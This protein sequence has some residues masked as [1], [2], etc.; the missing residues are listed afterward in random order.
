MEECVFCKIAKGEIKNKKTYE[1]DN[2][3]SVPDVKPQAP[4]HSLIISKKHFTTTLDL[5]NSLG[6]SFL[7]CVKN[8]ALKVM[9][10]NNAEGFNLHNNNFG[11]AGQFVNH[12]HMH[13][14]PRK[15]GDNFKPC[16]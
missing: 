14:V 3:F 6:S 2:F 11:V 5:P 16:L 10:E 13:L 9:K 4:G 12:F 7:D 15:K 1:N 8:T